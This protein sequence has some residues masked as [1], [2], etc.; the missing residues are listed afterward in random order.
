MSTI[1]DR[2]TSRRDVTSDDPVFVRGELESLR[3]AIP[4]IAF[5]EA[6]SNWPTFPDL[7]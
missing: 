2:L 5:S 7:K 3:D 4:E 1:A 6:A